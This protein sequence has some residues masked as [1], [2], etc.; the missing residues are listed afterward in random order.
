VYGFGFALLAWQLIQPVW[1]LPWTA[2]ETA[3]WARVTAIVVLAAIVPFTLGFIALRL[4]P[5]ARVS[6]V[7]TSE[8]FIAAVIAWAVLGQSL[9]APQILGGGLV[10][11][12]IL[13]A[14]T[15]RPTKDS[16]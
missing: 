4:L 11:A 3:V 8:P 12:G 2:T 14:Q 6:I 7:A 15:H 5:G 9:Q 13:I 1:T 10:L 16:I